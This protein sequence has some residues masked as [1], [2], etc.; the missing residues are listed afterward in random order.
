MGEHKI[1]PYKTRVGYGVSDEW[2]LFFP[3]DL[4]VLQEKRNAWNVLYNSLDAARN[5]GLGQ[6]FVF[7]HDR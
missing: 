2:M 4:I 7:A 6:A 3:D 1:R 5:A